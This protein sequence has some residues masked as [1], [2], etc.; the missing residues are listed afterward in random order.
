MRA[1]KKVRRREKRITTRRMCKRKETFVGR[2]P[3]RPRSRT[4]KWAQAPRRTRPLL[5]PQDS[6]GNPLAAQS[7]RELRPWSAGCRLCA[8]PTHS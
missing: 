5:Q 8:N 6:T 3:T 1:R 2:T 7:P 4:K